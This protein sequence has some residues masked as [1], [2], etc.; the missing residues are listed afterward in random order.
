MGKLLKIGF[1]VLVMIV[2]LLALNYYYGYTHHLGVVS[3]IKSIPDYQHQ[4]NPYRCDNM[5]EEFRD[6]CYSEVASQFLDTKFCDKITNTESKEDC[7]IKI[8]RFKDL[9]ACLSFYAKLYENLPQDE[10]DKVNTEC[11]ASYAFYTNNHDVCEHAPDFRQKDV[12]DLYRDMCYG[13]LAEKLDFNLE[14]CDKTGIKDRCYFKGIII[15]DDPSLCTEI[16]YTKS[17]YSDQVQL[18]DICFYYFALKEKKS[19]ICDGI[20]VGDLKRHCKM[21]VFKLNILDGTII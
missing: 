4:R 1:A 10:K 18:R 14:I 7:T 2:F 6:Y 19:E 21:N 8:N 12:Q 11:Y 17:D 9:D 3:Y 13:K 20:N 15:K 16:G 5:K